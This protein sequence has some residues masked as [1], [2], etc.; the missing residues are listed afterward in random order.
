VFVLCFSVMSRLQPI[1]REVFQFCSLDLCVCECVCLCV[2]VW[3]CVNV[4][5]CGVV[6]V[7][8]RACFVCVCECVC[9]CVRV[10]V[11]VSEGWVSPR[12]VSNGGGGRLKGERE[13]GVERGQEVR[14]NLWFTF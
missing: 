8:V 7:C 1:I 9:V 6:C 11:C 12:P 5:V 3:V 14:G 10:C 13:R 2:C 4:C